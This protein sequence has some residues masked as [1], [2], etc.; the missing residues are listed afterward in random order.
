MMNYAEL[1]NFH[2]V[3]SDYC[4]YKLSLAEGAQIIITVVINF[5]SAFRLPALFCFVSFDATN[6]IETKLSY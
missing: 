2:F 6:Q 1:C 5:N 4:I 3:F